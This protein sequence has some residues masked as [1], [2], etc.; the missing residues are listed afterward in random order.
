MISIFKDTFAERLAHAIKLQQKGKIVEIEMPKVKE[1]PQA[2]LMDALRASLEQYEKPR[3]ERA[4]C[5][6]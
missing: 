1:A 4:A 3:V 2:S 6:R 5:Q